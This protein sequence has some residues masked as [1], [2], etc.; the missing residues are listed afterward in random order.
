MRVLLQRVRRASVKVEGQTVGEIELG[1]VVLLGIGA[2]DQAADAEKLAEKIVHL[3]IF[4]DENGKF[5]R[6][7]LDMDGQVLLVSQFTLYADARKGRRPN[8]AGAAQPER[9][10]PLCEYFRHR[11]RQLGVSHVASGQFGATM[12]VE[13][14]N[15]GPVTIWLDSIDL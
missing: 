12:E 8:F 4:C 3:R 1:L 9:A 14:H 13:I 5:N 11:L 6:S 7:L 10:A 15:D 2:T